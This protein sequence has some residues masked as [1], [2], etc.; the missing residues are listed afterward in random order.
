M[1]IDYLKQKGEKKKDECKK[2]ERELGR[3]RNIEKMQKKIVERGKN[4]K[5]RM[6]GKVGIDKNER[7]KF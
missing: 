5:E 3:Y 6:G 4:I 2:R 7:E 1:K